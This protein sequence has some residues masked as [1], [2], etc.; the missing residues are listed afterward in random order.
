M[1]SPSRVRRWR[2]R[3]IGWA[4]GW[5]GAGA[6][7]LLLIDITDLPELIVG[8]GVAVIAASG[9][10]LAR[11]REEAGQRARPRWALTLHRALVKVPSDVFVVSLVV[12]PLSQKSVLRILA[13]NETLL[14]Q[15]ARTHAC[16][17]CATFGRSICV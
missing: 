5:V 15:F 8:A 17:F 11:A 13:R 1:S 6:L 10:E 4:F 14:A 16:M 3:T 9:F 2:R 7:Y 12:D